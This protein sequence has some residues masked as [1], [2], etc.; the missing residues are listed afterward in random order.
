M[1]TLSFK[2]PENIKRKL[3][4][5]ANKRGQSRAEIIRRALLEYFA[6]IDKSTNHSFY[7]LS[8]DLAGSVKDAP[9]LSSND[10]YLDEYG[11]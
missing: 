3:T 8:K 9:D 1:E 2:V 10:K 7:D 11:K 6:K 4:S 5:Y